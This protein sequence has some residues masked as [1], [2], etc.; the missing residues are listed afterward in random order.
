MSDPA[1]PWRVRFQPSAR[2][3][4]SERL[5]EPV[6]AAV[7]EFCAGPL[8]ENPHRVGK[9]LSGPFAGCHG[10]R[11]GSYRIIYRIE[12]GTRTV[13]VLDVDHRATAYRRR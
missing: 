1:R 3:A 11:R 2:R 7:I 13:Q 9:P 10:A 5:P 6:A 8:T 4:L 12:P